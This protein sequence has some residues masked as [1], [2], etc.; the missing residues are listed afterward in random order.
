M[1]DKY[2]YVPE[3]KTH[4]LDSNTDFQDTGHA[5]L[6]PEEQPGALPRDLTPTHRAEVTEWRRPRQ[7]KGVPDIEAGRKSRRYW[8]SSTTRR[9]RPLRRDTT[10]PFALGS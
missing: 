10:Q 2:Y 1:S 8:R 7:I 3:V 4:L 5:A 6:D 9:G